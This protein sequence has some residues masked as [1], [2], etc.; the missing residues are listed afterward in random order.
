MTYRTI[1]QGESV[2]VT[3][4]YRSN[5]KSDIAMY[6]HFFLGV[7]TSNEIRKRNVNCQPHYFG[8]GRRLGYVG[9]GQ[10]ASPALYQSLIVACS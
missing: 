3:I 1:T 10:R 2:S 8:G 7:K 9:E 6:Q 5:H 4:N